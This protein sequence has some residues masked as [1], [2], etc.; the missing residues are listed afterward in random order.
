MTPRIVELLW[1]G[2]HCTLRLRRHRP[3]VVIVTIT[4]R[5]LGEFGDAPLAELSHDVEREPIHLFVDARDVTG[6]TLDVSSQ[7][8]L[9]IRANR[10]RLTGISM[11]TARRFIQFHANMARDFADVR[12]RMQI[13]TDVAAWE[14]LL[15]R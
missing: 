3:G 12:D 10:D 4:G 11:L 1:E 8:A 2:E 6:A 9:W 7:W 15:A 14:A 5:D 13:F